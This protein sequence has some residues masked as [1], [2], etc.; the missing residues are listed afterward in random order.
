MWSVHVSSCAGGRWED[1]GGPGRGEATVGSRVYVPPGVVVVVFAC[2]VT[3]CVCVCVCV[4]VSVRAR[5]CFRLRARV[6]VHDQVYACVCLRDTYAC[7]MCVCDVIVVV[8]E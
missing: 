2:C 6:C 5:V 3:V 8:S 4:C 7:N 1:G